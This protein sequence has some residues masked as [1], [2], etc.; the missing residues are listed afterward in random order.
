MRKAFSSSGLRS[1]NRAGLPAR[2]N[3]SARLTR[4]SV[5]LASLAS[6][7]FP[8][9]FLARPSTRRSRLSRSASISS[10]SMVSMS[11]IGSIAP[12]TSATPG[13]TKQRTTWAM[14]STSRAWARNW[15]PRP[16]P[17]EA[18]L[19]RPAIS[20]KVSR[21]GLILAD[22]ASFAS[23]SR[24]GSGTITSPTFGSMV[25][26]GYFDAC[27]AAVAV[28]GLKTVDLPTLERPRMP[29]VKPMTLLGSITPRVSLVGPFRLLGNKESLG[30]HGEMH[31]V[32]EARIL[33]FR[34]QLGVVRDDGAQR[35]DPRPLVLGEVVEHVG[36]DQVLQAGMPDA[37]AHAPILVA[38]MRRDRAQ[39]VVAGDAAAGLDPHLAGREV[40]L[41][42]HHHDVG[43]P[44]LVEMRG[45]R[46]RAA[47]LVHVGAGQQQQRALAAERPLGRH[48]LK[49]PPPR[50]DAM[51]LGDRVDR[52]ETDIVSVAGVARTGI[53]EPDE[54]QHGILS[55]RSC[56]RK[57]A[58]SNLGPREQR[59]EHVSN[60]RRLLDRPPARAMTRRG[61]PLLLLRGRRL[62]LRCSGGGSGGSAWGGTRSTRGRSRARRGARGRAF[63]GN[64]GFR[65]GGRRGGS[66]GG[67]GRRLH[68]FRVA[69]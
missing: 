7:S 4:S 15:L 29:P 45:F 2:S 25:L 57:R 67:F 40:D 35:F 14:A 55:V 5:S 59:T 23:T 10:V 37:D 36:L 3:P 31:L 12:A 51:A 13:W 53:A 27:A 58:S 64:A 56:P 9:A 39:P 65:G 34:Q 54:E 43:E 52:R 46:H 21:V 33:A 20:T 42:V 63:G 60:R 30:L 32:L 44:E 6:L 18:P 48:A 69:R 19:T 66:S 17:L 61:M 22:F 50:T 24:R 41:V 26:N 1:T 11:A 68:L 16:S 28:S 49:A 8:F 38:D 62:L 47:R